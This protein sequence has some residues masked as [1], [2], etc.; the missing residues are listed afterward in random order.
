MTFD[1]KFLKRSVNRGEP[2]L[3]AFLRSLPE[4]FLRGYR[5]TTGIKHLIIEH[6]LSGPPVDWPDAESVANTLG[7]SRSTLHRLLTKAGHSLQQLK[8]EQRRNLATALLSRTDMTI[9]EVSAAVGYAEDAAFYRAFRR[10][11]GTN[12][13]DLRQKKSPE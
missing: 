8:D 4:A 10:W 7:V 2:E 11:Y 3:K 1:A 6:C 9:A 13:S 5:D 12:P